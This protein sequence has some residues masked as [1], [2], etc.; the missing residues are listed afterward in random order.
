MAVA[1]IDPVLTEEVSASAREFGLPVTTWEPPIAPSR[2]AVV[3]VDARDDFEM[4]DALV[5]SLGTPRRLATVVVAVVRD[6]DASRALDADADDLLLWPKER[7]TW[8]SRLRISARRAQRRMSMDPR[9]AVAL[10][11][12]GE[13]VELTD[14]DGRIEYVNPAFEEMFGYRSEE[15]LGRTPAEFL[16]SGFHDDAF[17]EETWNQVSSGHVWRGTLVSRRHDGGVVHCDTTVS[18]LFDEAGE[19]NGLIVIRRDFTAK[20][21]LQLRL[22][23]SE[24]L[25]ALG[26]LAAGISHEINNPLAFVLA[27]V[28][29]ALDL[30]DE[31]DGTPKDL[32]ASLADALAG[33]ERVRGIV[34]HMSLLAHTRG[35]EP[36]PVALSHVLRSATEIGGVHVRRVAEVKIHVEGDPR[37]WGHESE[38]GRIALNLLVN[39]AQAIEKDN[40]VVAHRVVVRAGVISDAE[41]FFEVEDDGIGMDEETR[42]RAF[43]PFFTTKARGTGTGLG[44]S[45][46]HRIVQSLGGRIS[47]ESQPGQGTTVRVV[48]PSASGHPLSGGS[49]MPPV[50]ICDV[51]RRI[52]V[53]D[54]E[55]GMGVALRRVFRDHDVEVQ[56]DGRAALER[57]EREA[58]DVVICDLSMPMLGGRE[59]RESLPSEAAIRDRWLYLTGGVLND[60]D[61]DYLERFEGP[62]VHKPF[63]AR[64][65]RA[66]ALGLAS[67]ND[68]S[69]SP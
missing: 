48:L 33:A 30:C 39:A 52:L 31:S 32:R 44:L 24:R 54:D 60:L 15:I 16:R 57:L 53:V 29:H 9:L 42:Q 50:P 46:S 63:R 8:A 28:E 6:E 41:V 64:T 21:E 61:R 65:L 58:F 37:A 13:A 4:L 7:A 5:R 19:V 14:R 22:E 55:P 20:H 2:D 45:L 56:S 12:V 62:V 18:P 11:H 27:N 49:T 38:L 40:V 35:G 47:I 43:D 59:L 36:G 69:P 1:S 68:S 25:S 34:R 66:L 26:T 17:Y 3:V 23:R 67:S 51:R 10:A